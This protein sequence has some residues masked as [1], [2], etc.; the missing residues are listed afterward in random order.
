MSLG[1]AGEV[2]LKRKGYVEGICVALQS[3]P[4]ASYSALHTTDK[5]SAP[6]NLAAE[7]LLG[8]IKEEWR[9]AVNIR[10]DLKRV[11]EEMNAAKRERD[12]EWIRKED[13][14]I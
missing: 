14:C 11:K 7:I 3:Q 9:E 4:Q 1:R 2:T 12:F 13:I 8:W 5:H 6:P 10:S